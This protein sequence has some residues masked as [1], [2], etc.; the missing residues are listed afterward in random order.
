MRI[1]PLIAAG[2]LIVASAT[3][4]VLAAGETPGRYVMHPAD[5]GFVRLDTE[6]GAVSLCARK[7]ALWSCQAMGDSGT[8]GGDELDRL[9]V[10]N[11][12]LKAEVKRLEDMLLAESR[13]LKPERGGRLELPS[14]EDVDKALTYLE[15]MFRKFRDKL[16]EFESEERRGT[17]L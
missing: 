5:G 4:P 1:F 13:N 7:D 3:L 6:T 9:R 15:R 12:E 17:P 2:A 16:K 8:G 10:E 11:R 14:E